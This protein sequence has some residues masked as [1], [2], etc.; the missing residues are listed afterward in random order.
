MTFYI[1]KDNTSPSITSNLK[2][3][4]NNAIS[5]AGA[6]VRFHMLDLDGTTKVDAA[7]SVTDGANGIVQYDWVSGDTDTIG[8]YNVEWEVTYGDGTIETFPNSDYE[9]VV[10]VD[11][12]L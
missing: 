11:K 7:G 9:I 6:S 12:L 2:D 1:K 3:Y 4:Q 10:V 5:V 8:T